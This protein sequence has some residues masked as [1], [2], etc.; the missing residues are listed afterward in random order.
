MINRNLISQLK[1][2]WRI[3]RL[4]SPKEVSD[5]TLSLSK[6]TY[7]NLALLQIWDEKDEIVW[8]THSSCS[9]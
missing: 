6:K 3:Y 4:S 8:K 7:L 5:K 1:F 2:L 9:C